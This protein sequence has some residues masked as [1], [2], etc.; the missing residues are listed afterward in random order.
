MESNPAI[1]RNENPLTRND[2]ALAC[3]LAIAAAVLVWHVSHLISYGL[4]GSGVENVWFE[5]DVSRVFN[6]INGRW[7]NQYRSKVHPIFALIATSV[8]YPIT[9]ITHCSIDDAANVFLSGVAALWAVLLYF[10]LRRLRFDAGVAFLTTVAG[11]A[12]SSALLFF[13][14]PE[15]YSLSSVSIL[16]AILLAILAEGK[17]WEPGGA[18]L[19]SAASLSIT[20]TN[21]MM[22]LLLTFDLRRF[23]R[24][25]QLS[26]NAFFVVTLAW[27]IERMLMPTAQFFT[28]WGEESKYV[29]RLS[30]AR[31]LKVGVA[32]FF[33]SAVAPSVEQTRDFGV[34]EVVGPLWPT[35]LSFQNSWPGSASPWGL[36][37]AVLW[38]AALVLG[39]RAV[40]RIPRTRIMTVFVCFLFLQFLEHIVYG[41]ETFMYALDWLPVLLIVAAAGFQAMGRARWP[42]LAVLVALFVINNAGEFN[43]ITSLVSGYQQAHPVAHPQSR[44]EIPKPLCEDSM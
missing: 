22:G 7:S 42:A 32:F 20:I 39:L 25:V 17:W 5:S 28:A 30:F 16:A 43:R 33:H 31:I 40:S 8:S 2:A 41:V 3:F 26:I 21:W 37:A 12:S 24:W 29:I 44:Q 4:R 6:N 23:G 15:T 13:T 36:A 14:V 18:V 38:G 10:V 27:T 19:A 9:A 1:P 34:G 11:L 35:G